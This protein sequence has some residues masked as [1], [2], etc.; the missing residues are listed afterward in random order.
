MSTHKNIDKICIV[1][2]I[3][4]L[5]LTVLFMN[6]KSLGLIAVVDED[7]ENYEG[8]EYF[9][10]NDLNGSWDTSK[11]T[12]I[13]LKGDSATISGDGAYSYDGDVY[14]AGGGYY[15]VSGSLTDGQLVVDAYSSSKVW[16]LFDGVDI[17]CSDNAGLIV[18][19]AEK[20][21]LT[22]AEGSKNSI[23]T[24]AEYS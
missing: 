8:D 7:A 1:V 22:L 16:I 15:V 13:T 24:G 6:G 12:V 20:V 18:N 10:A 9:S 21:F 3:L 11:A 19:E 23:S 17:Y 4:A 14:I 2:I 5:I